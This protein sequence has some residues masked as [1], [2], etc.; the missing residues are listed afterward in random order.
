[1]AQKLPNYLRTF[2]RRAG[3]TQNEVAFLLGTKSSYHISRYEHFSREPNLRIALACAVVLSAGLEELFAGVHE[4]IGAEVRK[5][6]ASLVKRLEERPPD[7]VTRQ[8]LATLRR[9]IS[10]RT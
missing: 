2:R 4:Q 1:M 8:K 3:L 5:R 7:R 10:K 9:V 6:A